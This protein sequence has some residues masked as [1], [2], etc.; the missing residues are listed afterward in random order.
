[1]QDWHTAGTLSQEIRLYQ[2]GIRRGIA[3]T[4]IT[5]GD[6]KD[7]RWQGVYSGIE[8]VP[9]FPCQKKP[10][11]RIGLWFHAWYSQFGLEDKVSR[12]DIVKTNQ[13]LGGLLAT[14]MAARWSTPLLVRCGYEPYR[15]VEASSGPWW[16]AKFI[17]WYARTVY[18]SA[19]RIHVATDNDKKYAVAQLFSKKKQPVINVHPNWVDTRRFRRSSKDPNRGSMVDGRVLA[20]GRSVGQKNFRLLGY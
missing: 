14:A 16:K 8:V 18:R 7:L 17:H 20:V 4:F 5:F 15:F 2:E 19:T 10:Q 12:P 3:F 11:S 1:M 6:K 13:I 9:I